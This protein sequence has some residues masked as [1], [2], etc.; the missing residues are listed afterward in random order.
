M[1]TCMVQA[2]KISR[3]SKVF[4]ITERPPGW[5]SG[6]KVLDQQYFGL[7]KAALMYTCLAGLS[8]RSVHDA[9]SPTHRSGDI[10]TH[11]QE[12]QELSNMPTHAQSTTHYL[13]T[14][15]LSRPRNA[16]V[17]SR[18][19]D[20]MAYSA[21]HPSSISLADPHMPQE[22]PHFLLELQ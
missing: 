6:A 9:N 8:F 3:L 13:S 4:R 1:C 10:C 7:A 18:A 15:P 2:C 20:H 19:I 11:P 16:A 12:E 22:A 17:L 5:A 14:T 21:N